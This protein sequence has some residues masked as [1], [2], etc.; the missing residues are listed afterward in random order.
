MDTAVMATR[1]G[2]LM[3]AEMRQTSEVTSAKATAASAAT[4]AR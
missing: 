1:R 3:L 2:A 4:N